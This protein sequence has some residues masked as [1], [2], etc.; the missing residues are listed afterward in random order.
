MEYFWQNSKQQKIKQNKISS[1][2]VNGATQTDPN[3]IAESFNKFFSEIGENL[4]KKKFQMI[5][6]NL[7][8]T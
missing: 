4:A 1:L 6:L 5:I 8:I 7:K 3:K 2:V